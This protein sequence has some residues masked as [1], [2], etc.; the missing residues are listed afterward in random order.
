MF[1]VHQFRQLYKIYIYSRI[2][3]KHLINIILICR[4]ISKSNLFLHL[5]L[6]TLSQ[7]NT[8]LIKIIESKNQQK[9]LY[10][11]EIISYTVVASKF[12]YFIG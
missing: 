3:V 8:L 1:G 6:V 11:I 2:F 5:F 12:N 4:F 10:L 9:Y 7:Q